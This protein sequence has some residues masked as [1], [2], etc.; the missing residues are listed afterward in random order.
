MKH[1]YILSLILCVGVLTA[2]ATPKS[3]AQLRKAYFKTLPEKNA[4]LDIILSK[5][6]SANCEAQE[7]EVT[8]EAQALV[9]IPPFMPMGANT[10]GS[11]N[12]QFDVNKAGQTVN[13]KTL[14]CTDDIYDYASRRALSQW[15]YNPRIINGELAGACGIK[16]TIKFKLIDE[17]GEII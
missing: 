9:R 10:S 13:I 5:R 7:G 1:A 4:E 17:R 6:E 12:M 11:C 2:C 16:N 8:R 14:S 15:K 3:N